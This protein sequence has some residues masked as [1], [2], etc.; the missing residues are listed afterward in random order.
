M[1]LPTVENSRLEDVKVNLLFCHETSLIALVS[2]SNEAFK[3]NLRLCRSAYSGSNRTNAKETL[4]KKICTSEEKIC[5][6]RKS[7][8]C[9][10][11]HSVA[12]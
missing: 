4:K 1:T 9:S 11:S 2:F 3:S 12:L 5:T 10:P 6:E 8:D 7:E